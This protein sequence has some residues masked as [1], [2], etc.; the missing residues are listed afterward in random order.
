MKPLMK[1]FN[2]IFCQV[3]TKKHH[4]SK[5]NCKYLLRLPEM[6]NTVNKKLQ[7]PF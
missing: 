1:M 4:M 2:K 3:F 6:Q 5:L 7:Q